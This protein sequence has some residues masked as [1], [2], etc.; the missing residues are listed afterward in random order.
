MLA[1]INYVKEM[2]VVMHETREEASVMGDG[3]GPSFKNIIIGVICIAAVAVLAFAVRLSG[4]GKNESAK[5]DGRYPMYAYY[6]DI[7]G[8]TAEEI[9]AVEKIKERRDGFVYAMNYSTEAFL[10]EDGNIGGYTALF[11][12]W[13]S[14]LFGIP[15][16]PE[17]REWDDLIEG[18]KSGAVDFSG[19]LTA[20][21]ERREIYFMTDSIAERSIKM[22]RI[23]G[24]ERLAELAGSRPL[25]YV[26][27]DGT[28]THDLVAPHVK[29]DYEPFFVNDYDTVYQMLKNGAADAFFD[30]SPAEAAFDIYG[31]VTAEDFFPLIY[32]SVS[33]TAQNP[34]LEPVISVAQKALKSG[35]SYHLAKM[36]NN[37]HRDYLRHKFFMKLTPEEIEYVRAHSAPDNAVP[38]AIEYDNYPVCFY[39]VHEKEW[40]GAA[41]D[42]L[43]KIETF[44]GLAFKPAND[45]QAKWT[46]ILKILEDGGAS[47]ITE[48]IHS[49]EREGRYLWTDK[50]Y[51]QDF[52]A[53]LS[54]LDHED[55]GINEILYSRVA[56]IT[57][58]AYADMFNAWFPNH[59]N[60]V[61]YLSTFNAMDALERGDVDLVM[62]SRNLLLSTTN[63]MERPGFKAN[64][65]FNHT[66]DS[67]FGFNVNEPVLRSIISKAQELVNTDEIS[68]RWIRRVFD[69]R[70]KMA[71]AQR[72]WLI[73]VSVLLF[74][75]L[76]LFSIMLYRRAREGRILE[77]TVRERTKELEIQAKAAH[78][79]SRTKS[80]FLANMSHEIRTPINAV[81]GMAAIARSSVDLD[82]IYDCL[83]KITLASRQ[84]LGLINDI[85]D[86]SKIE[87]K[88]F[89]LAHEPFDLEAM[90]RNV[91]SIIGVRA[92]EKLQRFVVD[93][94]PDMPEVVIGDEVRLSQILLN[95]L[96]NAVKFTPEKGEVRLSIKQ[97]GRR[98]DKD[99]FEILVSDSGIG[100]TPEQQARLFNAFVQADSGTAKRF[101]GT[102][103]G[104]VISKSLA[105]LM[106]GDISVESAPNEG[107][108]F[109]VRLSLETGTPD[110]LQTAHT[111]VAEYNFEGRV[112]LL[113]EDIAINREIAVA[114]LEETG[115]TIDCAENGQIAVKMFATAPERYDIILMDVQMPVMDGYQ[116]TTAIRALNTPRA[117]L[118]PIIAMT[119]N[120]FAE[121]VESC[122]KAGMD[123][124]I[125]KPIELAALLSVTDKY[126]SDTKP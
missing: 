20:T 106:G 44:T 19:E 77:T 3:A 21:D 115:V 35:A 34:E 4:D 97:M 87:A 124:H 98:G 70:G 76:S 8:V 100:I 43:R 36:Y 18:L 7:P 103:L 61:E 68:D 16:K 13:L 30:E 59:N 81:T 122:R 15:F 54:T 33:L 112:F 56:L 17:T 10:N 104:L 91:S 39:N 116:A 42:V 86:M 117:R 123:A 105:E 96:S 95:L 23:T 26:F 47:M 64:I 121:D 78:E 57:D 52:Y 2:V 6:R 25:R 48:L 11:C 1:R 107:S 55:I 29:H 119:A 22:M 62:A 120:A 84:L 94:S 83:D 102:G 92:T 72:P 38:V 65:V 41:M 108:R 114:L 46:D 80:E 111:A 12:E 49:P 51:K 32:S 90:V 24:S 85:L 40:Q 58:T 5:A 89:E 71:Q 28:T 37:G 82:R 9:E 79:A 126:L 50:A 69:Y 109:T 60:T 73:G 14:G 101:G 75:V 27:L 118:I 125:A 67:K 63:F 74:C 53:L 88:K 113:V 66:Y 110:M 45:S 99:D 31:D 93:V